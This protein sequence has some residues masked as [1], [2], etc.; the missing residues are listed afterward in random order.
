MSAPLALKHFVHCG[1]GGV[2]TY[3]QAQFKQANLALIINFKLSRYQTHTTHPLTQESK[4][5]LNHTKPNQ[6]KPNLIKTYLVS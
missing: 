5:K 4:Q 2:H 1:G 6:T 3:C